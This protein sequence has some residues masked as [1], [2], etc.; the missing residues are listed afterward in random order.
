MPATDTS[1]HSLRSSHREAL[2]E[3]LFTGEIMKR[4]CKALRRSVLRFALFP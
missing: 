1:I 2:L 4:V 3:H